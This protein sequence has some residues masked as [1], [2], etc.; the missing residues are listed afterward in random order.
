MLIE[1]V[2]VAVELAD[3]K[4]ELQTST[5]SLVLA[6]HTFCCRRLSSGAADR[7]CWSPGM[8]LKLASAVEENL[9]P[10][11]CLNATRRERGWGWNEIVAKRKSVG[12]RVKAGPT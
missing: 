11:P 8:K 2:A 3:R 9:G 5:P 6:P 10:V 7:G 1:A 4:E 12:R